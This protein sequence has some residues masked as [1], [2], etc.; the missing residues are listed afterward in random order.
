MTVRRPIAAAHKAAVLVANT[1][2]LE[3]VSRLMR[4][5]TSFKSVIANRKTVRRAGTKHASATRERTKRGHP[6]NMFGDEPPPAS[7][8]ATSNT[9]DSSTGV[10]DDNKDTLDQPDLPADAVI[11]DTIEELLDQAAEWERTV[12][13]SPSEWEDDEDD[14]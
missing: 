13:E 3:E 8:A 10:S 14:M 2:D 9:T 5:G 4:E 12:Y 1:G 6:A 7:S 11:P